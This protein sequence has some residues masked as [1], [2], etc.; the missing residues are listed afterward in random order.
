MIPFSFPVLNSYAVHSEHGTDGDHSKVGAGIASVTLNIHA[1]ERAA[2]QSD[3]GINPV[4][5]L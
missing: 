5:R 4:Q 2:L 3:S 1:V